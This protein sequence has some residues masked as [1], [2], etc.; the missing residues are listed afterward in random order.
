MIRIT[1]RA[2]KYIAEHGGSVFVYETRRIGMCCGRI[3]LG[4]SV[5]LGRPADIEEYELQT[6]AGV[7]LYIP[8]G[9]YSP[10]ELT[11]EVNSFGGLFKTLSLEGWKII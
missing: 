4:P 6:E 9:F 8:K 2:Q 10:F 7:C 1:E 5:R 11:L 3:N